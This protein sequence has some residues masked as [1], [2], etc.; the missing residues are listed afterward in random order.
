M[1]AADRLHHGEP[2]EDRR[3][4]WML[5]TV[6][7]AGDH[8][9]PLVGR[10]RIVVAANLDEGPPEFTHRDGDDGVIGSELAFSDLEALLQFSNSVF[11]SPLVEPK[12]TG[13]LVKRCA[14]ARTTFSTKGS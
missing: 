14:L 8:Q 10:E 4:G 2:V 3:D 7:P 9:R 6:R 12:P 13:L 5:R 1:I 11:E